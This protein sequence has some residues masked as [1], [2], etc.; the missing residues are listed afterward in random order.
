MPLIGLSRAMI[1]CA[2]SG[3]SQKEGCSMR[4]LS[5]SRW[6]RLPATSKGVPQLGKAGDDGVGSAAEVRVHESP[7]R[8]VVDR[9]QAD[10][11][12]PHCPNIAERQPAA[13]FGF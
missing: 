5:W 9:P 1:S 2:L 6:A 12:G 10:G 7:R 3:L 13:Q 11:R 4:A 8:K